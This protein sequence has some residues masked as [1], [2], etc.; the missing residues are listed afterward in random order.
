MSLAGRRFWRPQQS[1]TARKGP[2]LSSAFALVLLVAI[3]CLSC[4]P[5]VPATLTRQLAEGGVMA[6]P[7]GTEYQQLV[8]VVR[9]AGK[10]V[11]T[12]VLGCRF[13]R[14][15]GREGWPAQ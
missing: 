2:R 13:V 4:A 8:I 11:E 5:D 3:L 15:I 7:V 1:P 9:R 10:V 6:V 12:P 14:L